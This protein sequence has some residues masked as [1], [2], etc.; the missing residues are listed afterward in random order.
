MAE[1]GQQQQDPFAISSVTPIDPSASIKATATAPQAPATPAAAPAAPAAPQTAG[2][3]HDIV[4]VTKIGTAAQTGVPAGVRAI[5]P[6]QV[7]QRRYTAPGQ[8]VN[9]FT[10]GSTEE[11]R[12]L[13]RFPNAHLVP[14]T[15]YQRSLQ[16]R[17]TVN[18]ET[19][20]AQTARETAQ[21]HQTLKK[22][23]V[24]TGAAA[25]AM[26]APELLPFIAPELAAGTGLG[27]VAAGAGLEAGGAAAG[28]AAG[29]AVTGE[30]P[31][32]A[33][34]LKEAGKN[35]LVYGGTRAAFGAAGWS[36]G[37]IADW[38][39][40]F[41]KLPPNLEEASQAAIEQAGGTG[42]EGEQGV[43]S[44][45]VRNDLKTAKNEMHQNY[46]TK[47]NQITK[48]ANDAKVPVNIR[49]SVLQQ[50]ANSLLNDSRI[51]EGLQEALGAVN[52]EMR[53]LDPLLHALAGV[54]EAGNAVKGFNPRYTWDEMEATRQMIGKLSRAAEEGSETQ[55]DLLTLRNSI[56]ETMEQSAREAQMPELAN[57]M[58]NL[59][60]QY[61]EKI[62]LFNN[63]AI[64]QLGDKNPNA[65]ADIL[66]SGNQSIQ[67]VKNLRNLIGEDN[68]RSVQGSVLAKLVQGASK[69]ID[70]TINAK[71]LL[72]SFEKMNP[73]V[74]QALWGEDLPTVQKFFRDAVKPNV[75]GGM[76]RNLL[77]SL[78]HTSTV[79]RTGAG[80]G[81]IMLW[82][83][84]HGQDPSHIAQDMLAM[85]LL[86]NA[87]AIAVRAARFG[88]SVANALDTGADLLGVP[89]AAE[90]V[91]PVAAE[92][93][94]E[95]A[96]AVTPATAVPASEATGK[97]IETIHT[98]TPDT[99]NT[100]KLRKDGEDI[101]QVV[102]THDGS[103]ASVG[104][105]WVDS[106]V[107]GQGHGQTL[108]TE[109]AKKARLQGAKI[110]TS[111]PEGEMTAAARKPWE[112]LKQKGLPVTNTTING[113]PGYEMDLSLI[114]ADGKPI[115][116]E[117]DKVPTTKDGVKA[118]TDFGK[119]AKTPSTSNTAVSKTTAVAASQAAPS[120]SE[121]KPAN[122]GGMRV[123]SQTPLNPQAA[124][125]EPQAKLGE[126]VPERSVAELKE[127]VRNAAA[128]HEVPP[129][130]LDAQAEQ[131]SKYD[132][133]ARSH[134]GAQGLMQFMPAT[135]RA[136]GVV[137]PDDPEESADRGAE[138]M[139]S[140]KKR[141]GTWDK[142]LAGYNS[143]PDKVQD[144]IDD[145]G[146]EWLYHLPEETQNYVHTIMRR[147]AIAKTAHV[148][149]MPGEEAQ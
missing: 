68:M 106:T 140:L 58:K 1:T 8:G 5:Q 51:P 59:R 24:G 65:V 99:M 45:K 118:T 48:A 116:P 7:T 124:G 143:N 27:T 138:L 146:D 52:P 110:L 32:T 141:F 25:G 89:R 109:A 29:Q 46:E 26:L 93:V 35:A 121:K 28:T 10:A 77:T 47:F 11:Q 85:G 50:T 125:E 73:D 18:T 115:P 6:P 23:A 83:L 71:T 79:G 112:A 66:L 57:D 135:A 31:L 84:A 120:E 54:D 129:D 15:S 130:L 80:A 87:P 33:E 137:N 74:A 17:E 113:K 92:P 103:T 91:A 147:F 64:K 111:D 107:R 3:P 2:N 49:G 136:M 100:I 145:Y 126:E 38:V 148:P 56:D 75:Q 44:A 20:T 105:S 53:R 95:A 132:P 82:D 43:A 81:G 9:E 139:A 133:R 134:K 4:S 60:G 88:P 21:A 55:R 127:I 102:F 114:D 119:T 19:P 78:S 70:G 104:H 40:D 13:Q 90:A 42:A 37:Q 76:L 128:D 30:N 62:N 98:G 108:L 142:A 39:R 101:G 131:E 16:P 122:T 144:A 22:T 149:R 86:V 12:F 34:N 94:A 63:N 14:Q 36:L 123:V 61:A 97:G 72:S 96:P 67:N 69:N 41:T 117:T